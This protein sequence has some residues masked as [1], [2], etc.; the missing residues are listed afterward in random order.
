MSRTAAVWPTYVGTCPTVPETTRKAAVVAGLPAPVPIA[1]GHGF[2]P[3]CRSRGPTCVTAR[4]RL[5]VPAAQH[6]L[7][8]VAFLGR[9]KTSDFLRWKRS[10]SASIVHLRQS[11][12]LPDYQSRSAFPSNSGS[13]AMLMAIRRASS[14]VNTFA[15]RVRPRR[16]GSKRR[17]VPAHWRPGLHNRRASGWRARATES[18]GMSS[19]G[20]RAVVWPPPYRRDLQRRS[21]ARTDPSRRGKPAWVPE[22]VRL[23]TTVGDLQADV[24]I[25]GSAL[26]R[27]PTI[28]FRRRRPHCAFPVQSDGGSIRRVGL[29]SKT[30]ADDYQHPSRCLAIAGCPGFL[31]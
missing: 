18:G 16:R 10:T 19:G 1:P 21:L 15:C 17:R 30:A 22:S 7:G 20:R 23:A 9:K 28:T 25:E 3:C 24:F 12:E 8:R 26:D 11:V 14:V 13:R 31:P 27:F 6:P 2:V 5:F 29:Q 4:G